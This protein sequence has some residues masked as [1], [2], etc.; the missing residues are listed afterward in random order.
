MNP[1]KSILASLLQSLPIM[2]SVLVEMSAAQ[3]ANI[4]LINVN[5]IA[6]DSD[7]VLANQN[8]LVSGDRIVAVGP[9]DKLRIPLNA[10]RIESDQPRYLIPGLA[11]L[12]GHI[13]PPTEPKSY[14][15]NVLFLYVANGVTTVRG[16]LGHPGQ[17]ELRQQANSGK[18]ISPSLYLAG[19]AFDGGLTPEQASER[20]RQQK[21]EGWDYL[22][23]L[24]GPSQAEYDAVARTAKEVQIP[25][26]GHVPRKV[27]IRHVLEAGQQTVDH[28]DGY[29]EYL[30]GD[31]GPVSDEKLA[32]VVKLTKQSGTWV[33]PTMVVWENLFGDTPTD[34]VVTYD[35]LK[36][37]PPALVKNWTDSHRRRTSGAGFN[38]AA[39]HFRIENRMRLLHAMNEGG[40]KILFGTDSPQQFSVP[41]FS[42]YREMQRMQQ[43]GMTPFQILRSATAAAGEYFQD[44]DKLGM[45]AAGHRADLVLLKANPLDD[46]AN[47]A[48][49]AG[50]MVRGR[51]LSEKDIAAR[52]DQIA[53]DY[54]SRQGK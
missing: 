30:G 48:K 29:I 10:K 14:I 40:V 28:L 35:G 53:S 43:A 13:P 5:V 4:A 49:Q 45:I 15:D 44:K 39:A 11:E 9:A 16:M 17:L 22:K 3:D 27:G 18:T 37:L 12:H 7:R 46:I 50:V 38:R 32:E 6:M 24:W 26:V 33:V 41:G 20:A 25:F 52:L 54:A 42:I 8:V 19:P 23:I 1:I 2:F 21:R 36:Y 31:A 47:V 34:S 51:W